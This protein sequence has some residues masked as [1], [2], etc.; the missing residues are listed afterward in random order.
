MASSL[1]SSSLSGSRKS[2]SAM[3]STRFFASA[4]C[5]AL[6]FSSSAV[7]RPAASASAV[8][9]E[10]R[11][12]AGVP[13]V[14]Q[15]SPHFPR[16]PV[17]LQRR[18]FSVENNDPLP[19]SRIW[20]FAELKKM[21]EQPDRKIIIVDVREP[22]ELYETGKIPGA[23]NIPITTAV[24]SF[25][26]KG[27]DFEDVYGFPLPSKDTELLFYCK[28]GVRAKGAAALAK[29]AGY[30]KVGEYPGSWND[31]AKNQGPVEKVKGP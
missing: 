26:L 6:S 22:V 24:Q 9:A 8:A 30:E 3:V 7:A 29:N 20:E 13:K 14:H 5:G 18:N 10:P 15:R 2:A 25:H 17:V 19:G 31:W 28:A 21:V 16:Q 4:L 11:T 23:I 12:A 1:L 27:E